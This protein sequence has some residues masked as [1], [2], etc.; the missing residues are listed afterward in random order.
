MRGCIIA[1]V[2]IWIGIFLIGTGGLV[3]DAVCG[4]VPTPSPSPTASS[5]TTIVATALVT[6]STSDV[7]ISSQDSYCVIRTTDQNGQ[8]DFVVG[9]PGD[10]GI[11]IAFEQIKREPG[12]PTAGQLL[13]EMEVLDEQVIPLPGLPAPV[14][15]KRGE[16]VALHS[17]YSAGSTVFQ[18]QAQVVRLEDR[19]VS[20]ADW[21]ILGLYFPI[22][23]I[24]VTGSRAYLHYYTRI[25]L[26]VMQ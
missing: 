22:G 19:N 9:Q 1:S 18:K 25:E 11:P 8:Q 16:T 21:T 17:I 26:T 13:I 20:W 23:H 7:D 15:P 14:P 2:I 6:R 12:L 3:G 24:E 10:P 5:S 4:S